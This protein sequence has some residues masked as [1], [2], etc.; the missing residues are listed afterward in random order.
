MTAFDDAL[1]LIGQAVTPLG[2]ENV[3][4]AAAAGRTLARDLRARADAPAQPTA[5]RDGYAVIDAATRAGEPL[6][7]IG[8][9]R[10]GA[11]FA[12]RLAP[13]QAVRI[14]TGAAMPAGADRCVMQEYAHSTGD[15]VTFAPG[16][17]PATHVRPAGSDFRAGDVLLPSG[18]LL[19]PAALVAAAAADR[20][21]LDVARSPRLSIIATGDELSAPGHAHA[22]AGA[23]PDS[24]TAAVAALATAHGAT[25][26]GTALGADD[27]AALTD[28]ASAALAR[29]DILVIAG[30][31][32]VGDHD[33][34]QA[35][36]AA[37]GFAPLFAKVAMKPGRPVWAGRAG[38]C[39]V[40]GLP[41]NPGSALVTARL[42]LAPMLA[43]LQ[44]RTC[45]DVLAW[46]RLPLAAPLEG[47]GA[48]ETFTRAR[49]TAAGLV[50][51]DNQ[52]SG[53]QATLAAAHWLIRR[54]PHSPPCAAGDWVEAV[55]M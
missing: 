25:I 39:W 35:M 30:G 38:S 33:H 22:R 21:A 51:L 14:F 28:L 32:S 7:I 6:A 16:Y 43:R 34:A 4:F 26:V 44:G 36:V 41:G 5:M 40:I 37:H 48:R 18:T 55:A 8:T 2:H 19:T 23:I 42:L 46:H 49:G 3:P 52:D 9:A 10:P 54:P 47:A 17:G 11:P 50:A 12:G 45:A 15:S 31:A 29:S 1:A 27:L 20:A 24:I 53:A 13:G